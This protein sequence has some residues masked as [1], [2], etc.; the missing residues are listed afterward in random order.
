MRL[1]GRGF[2]LVG[3]INV[4]WGSF[5]SW[6]MFTITGHGYGPGGPSVEIHLEMVKKKMGRRRG[7]MGLMIMYD[8]K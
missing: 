7:K 5:P 8:E 4:R 6:K 3:L 1:E 2:G